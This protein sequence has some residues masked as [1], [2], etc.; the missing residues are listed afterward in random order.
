MTAEG[1]RRTS[2]DPAFCC[3]SPA[4]SCR[5]SLIRRFVR[6]LPSLNSSDGYAAATIASVTTIDS[7]APPDTGA[8]TERRPGESAT[9]HVVRELEDLILSTLEPG[10]TLPS[11]SELADR[12]SVSRLTVREAMKFLQARG[13]VDIR[14]G[15][16]AT[17]A[18]PTAGAARSF[19]SLMVRRDPRGLLELL[20]I[21]RA[22][23]VHIATLAAQRATRAGVRGVELALDAMRTA[24][25]D[26]DDFNRADVEFH[27]SLA[28]ATGNRTLSLLI[29]A[30]QEPLHASRLRS[31]RG[32]L[33]RG[34][35][36]DEV[37]DQ[38]ARI[39][40]RVKE[41]DPKGAAQAMRD[42]LTSTEQ[43]LR[44]ALTL[45]ASDD[46]A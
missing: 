18:P 22:L 8:A 7:S 30:L 25:A 6:P 44:A 41:H 4:K 24:T 10:A 39:I 29:E 27:E 17:V 23:E 42:H 34:F 20:E 36:I 13:F 15:R 26:S 11:E 46:D 37:V 1:L 19:F 33:A 21:R 2:Q 45:Q 38:H 28:A 31:I 12:L 16:R 43:D 32:H 35:G 9:E 5:Y 3:V 40:E 14:Q